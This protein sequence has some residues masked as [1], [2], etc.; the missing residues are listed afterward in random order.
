MKV[1][2]ENKIS[3]KSSKAK[4]IRAMVILSVNNNYIFNI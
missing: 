3:D 1:Q 2:L 4:F